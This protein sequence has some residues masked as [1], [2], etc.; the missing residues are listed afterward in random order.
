LKA[1]HVRTVVFNRGFATGLLAYFDDL[2]DR[3]IEYDSWPLAVR[4]MVIVQQDGAPA[5]RVF[6]NADEVFAR[7]DASDRSIL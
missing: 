4:K 5:I 3:G 2:L 7:T 6:E 1:R